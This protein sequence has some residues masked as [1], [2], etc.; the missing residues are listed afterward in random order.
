MRCLPAWVVYVGWIGIDEPHSLQI[1]PPG[2]LLCRDLR[3]HSVP[4]GDAQCR[5][6]FNLQ[7]VRRRQHAFVLRRYVRDTRRDD[8]AMVTSGS[9]NGNMKYNGIMARIIHC[10][11][12]DYLWLGE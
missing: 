4:G 11:T 7:R 2:L 9:L 1:M 5:R 12:Y 10:L 8:I 3:R 6:I